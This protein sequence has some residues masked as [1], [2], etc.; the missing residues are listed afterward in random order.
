[1]MRAA[2]VSD[3]DLVYDAG[4]YIDEGNL[5]DAFETALKIKD[6]LIKDPILYKIFK[7][8]IASDNI[9]QASSVARQIKD[10][11][12]KNV[13]FAEIYKKYI[14]TCTEEQG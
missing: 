5:T 11:K 1:M 7:T 6:F 14:Q 13:A 8:W 10:L 4:K 9:T 2:Q 12:I 3:S